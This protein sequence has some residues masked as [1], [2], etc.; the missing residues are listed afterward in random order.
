MEKDLPNDIAPGS[1][2]LCQVSPNV[3]CGACCGLYNVADPSRNNLEAMLMRRSI[4]FADVPRTVTGIDA[5]KARVGRAEPQERPFPD[6]HHCAF[7]GMIDDGGRR[8]GCLLHP[9]AKGNGGLDWRGLSY[10]GGMACRTYF[11]PSARR[12]PARWLTAVCQVMDD[13]YL[14]GLVVTE[15]RL[16]TA[17]FTALEKRLGRT[18]NGEDFSQRAPAVALSTMLTTLKL[19]WP[20]RRREA[21]GVC[22]YFFE[23]GQ[24]P[25]PGVK[26]GSKILASS[27]FEAI[28]RE[29]DSGFSS[30]AEM[31]AAKAE[32][33]AMLI[34]LATILK[35]AES[36]GERLRAGLH[37]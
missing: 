22:N 34:G 10:Y 31:K 20:F 35:E 29:L 3:S 30:V 12:L 5:F 2:Y 25:R 13:W 24:Y 6:F 32:I 19:K 11:C 8:V 1:V 4:G 36:Y 26:L 33:E 7:L 15:R 14:H 37:P 23:D 27:R 28:F 17:L 18:V 9:L 16:L 21:P